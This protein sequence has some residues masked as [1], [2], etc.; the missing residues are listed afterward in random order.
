V[1]LLGVPTAVAQY[2]G[3]A[4]YAVGNT[5]QFSDALN[6]LQIS[7]ASQSVTCGDNTTV[8]ALQGLPLSNMIQGGVIQSLIAFKGDAIY[9]QITGDITTSDLRV[10]AVTGSVGTL[11]PNSVVPTPKGLAYIAPDGLRFIGQDGTSSDPVGTYGTGVNLPF[12]YAVNPTRI[13]AAFDKNLLRVSVQNGLAVGQPFEEYWFDM[14][15]NVWSGP[16]SFPAALIAPYHVSVNNFVLFAAGINAKL[17]SS[18]VQPSATSTYTENGVAMSWVWQP[19]LLPDNQELAANQV[20]ESTLGLSLPT[21]QAITILAMDESGN[22]LDTV[23]LSG[24]GMGQALWN[25]FNW[26]SGVW[27]GA[28]SPFQQYEL[29]WN[30]PLVF[31][32]MTV[33]IVGASQSGFSIGNLYAKY[34]SLGYAGGH[35]P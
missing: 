7:V 10:N 18:K 19:T 11:A 13:A 1:P 35:T 17:W 33:R 9:Y 23:S 6:P 12:L 21:T 32:Q 24:N 3:R 8:N 34:Q 22:T 14:N 20:V 30:K 27:G 31:K 25:A 5:V 29:P 2:N 4:W 28:V 26:G 16:H 15:L